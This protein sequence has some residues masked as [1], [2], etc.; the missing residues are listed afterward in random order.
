LEFGHKAS[1]FSIKEEASVSEAELDIPFTLDKLPQI[2]M[3]SGFLE[4]K[5]EWTLREII[6]KLQ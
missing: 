6:S 1:K 4:T 5:K 2:K 3:I